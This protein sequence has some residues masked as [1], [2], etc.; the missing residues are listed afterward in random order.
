MG[1]YANAI[2]FIWFVT[3][4]PAEREC[5]IKG[6]PG[7]KGA[8]FQFTHKDALMGC[9]RVIKNLPALSGY[10]RE[11]ETTVRNMFSTYVNRLG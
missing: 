6:C 1:T 4:T 7:A 11:P 10:D 3:F 8:A 2:A 9:A 5:S